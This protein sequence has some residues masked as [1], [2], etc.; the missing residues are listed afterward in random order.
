MAEKATLIQPLPPIAQ[1]PSSTASRP[2][3][4]PP[5]TT[6]STELQANMDSSM[7]IF[8]AVTYGSFV[9]TFI[10]AGFA[11]VVFFRKAKDLAERRLGLS[12]KALG[13]ALLLVSLHGF[14]AT[15]IYTRYLRGEIDAAPV[16]FTILIWLIL[17]LAI[18]YLTNRLLQLKEK[19]KVSESMMDGLFLL[20]VFLCITLAVSPVTNANLSLIFS[21]LALILYTIPLAR[22]FVAYKTVKFRHVELQQPPLQ[23]LLYCLIFIPAMPVIISLLFIFKAIG[24]DTMLCITNLVA[25]SFIILVSTFMLMTIKVSTNLEKQIFAEAQAPTATVDPLVEELLAE[26]ARSAKAS[27]ESRSQSTEVTKPVPSPKTEIPTPPKLPKKPIKQQPNRTEGLP[28]APKIPQKPSLGDK[29]ISKT[30]PNTPPQIK[31]PA[32]P[33]KRI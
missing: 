18:G 5:K 27:V 21:L 9:L 17:G 1:E 28:K 15:Y 26:E 22:F 25:F 30:A 6:A 16:S 4:L 33:K 31:A 13:G 7:S 19:V 29:A 8:Q 11:A 12:S 14:F 20:S 3:E 24:P 32:K 2:S 10:F 23:K